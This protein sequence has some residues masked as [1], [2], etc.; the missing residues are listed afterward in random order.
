[1]RYDAAGIAKCAIQQAYYEGR[2]DWEKPLS[3]HLF[4]IRIVSIGGYDYLNFEFCTGALLSGRI[5]RA[6]CQS[7]PRRVSGRAPETKIRFSL[8]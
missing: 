5:A 3:C 2:F 8:V 7:V 1:M 4:P 6:G